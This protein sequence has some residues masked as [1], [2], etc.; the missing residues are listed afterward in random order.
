MKR[1]KEKR[2]KGVTSTLYSEAIFF[3]D[4]HDKQQKLLTRAE[5]IAPLLKV[6]E[7]ENA[8]LK[9]ELRSVSS[10]LA[11]FIDMLELLIDENRELRE[12]ISMKNADFTKL[13]ETVALNE[14][15]HVQELQH[16]LHIF[17]EENSILLKHLD[18]M[19]RYKDNYQ[20]FAG[21]K[22]Q[23]LLKARDV[24]EQISRDF[25]EVSQREQLA[26]RKLELLEPK[27]KDLQESLLAKEQE[28][29]QV[30]HEQNTEKNQI[31]LLQSQLELTKS[32]LNDAE[33]LKSQ[34][35]DQLLQENTLLAH[36]LKDLRSELR[37]KDKD[38]IELREELARVKRDKEEISSLLADSQ[39]ELNEIRTQLGLNLARAEQSLSRERDTS[40]RCE[41]LS[42]ELQRATAKAQSLEKQLF[43]L[44]ESQ[45]IELSAKHA[46]FE[47]LIEKLK[48]KHKEHLAVK[49]EEIDRI[50]KE[51]DENKRVSEKERKEAHVLREELSEIKEK[52]ED[53]GHQRVIEQ[54]K[55]ELGYLRKELVAIKARTEQNIAKMQLEYKENLEEIS[56]K[57]ES[58]KEIHEKE[59]RNLEDLQY[60]IN[61][62]KKENIELSNHNRELLENQE[63]LKAELQKLSKLQPENVQFVMSENHKLRESVKLLEKKLTEMQSPNARIPL[64]TQNFKEMELKNKQMQSQIDDLNKKM[65]E[66]AGSTNKFSRKLFEERENPYVLSS[67]QQKTFE[68]KEFEVIGRPG[69]AG[70]TQL[71]ARTWVASPPTQQNVRTVSDF[72]GKNSY[73]LSNQAYLDSPDNYL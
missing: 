54:Q 59:H 42:R 35:N 5:E 30:R 34:E 21:E 41:G 9:G 13:L 17:S 67:P 4:S 7:E 55:L 62:L 33:T 69:N 16:K 51:L 11:S 1:F 49:E 26:V 58:L 29:E 72:K 53:C 10:D 64:E 50:L 25:A 65:Q 60:E 71:Q 40:E 63:F 48:A 6:L 20:A 61:L 66:Y 36:N 31:K 23:E 3:E 24:Y 68:N 19:K 12:H 46:S 45:K 73:F 52:H 28:C 18:E 15:E 38:F 8:L 43:S 56:G 57:Y 37:E 14:G 27:L 47:K 2:S 22:D 32:A 70:N 44:Q 39:E